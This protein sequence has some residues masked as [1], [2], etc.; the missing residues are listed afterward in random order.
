MI[1]F[2]LIQKSKLEGAECVLST[3]TL[4]RIKKRNTDKEKIV[5]TLK[6]L[7]NANDFEASKLYYSH[8]NEIDELKMAEKNITHLLN[9]QIKCEEIRKNGF[10]LTMPIGMLEH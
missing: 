9:T 5:T 7:L 1:V 2:R 8:V 4:T 3:E 10:L 6:F